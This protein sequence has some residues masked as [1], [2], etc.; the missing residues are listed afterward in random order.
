MKT[1][2][3]FYKI[4]LTCPKCKD[5][6]AT[7]ANDVEL[8]DGTIRRKC[9]VPGD[10]AIFRRHLKSIHGSKITTQEALDDFSNEVRT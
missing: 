4:R 9:A 1:I 10:I 7:L 2:R 5:S 6:F 3:A 8:K